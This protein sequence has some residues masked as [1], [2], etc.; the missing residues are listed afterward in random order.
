MCW[1]TDEHST[2]QQLWSERTFQGLC[3]PERTQPHLAAVLCRLPH[4][5]VVLP[6][7]LHWR[8][9]KG[10]GETWFTV[11]HDWHWPST[12]AV[13]KRCQLPFKVIGVQVGLMMLRSRWHESMK[14]IARSPCCD[15]NANALQSRQTATTQILITAPSSGYPTEN[16]D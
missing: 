13:T 3:G 14:S 11:F 6:P 9:H 15:G 8:S 1:K 2:Q 4:T 7:S 16:L 5:E 10:S 12:L